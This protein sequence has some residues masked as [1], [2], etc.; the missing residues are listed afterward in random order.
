MNGMHSIPSRKSIELNFTWN[1]R[2]PSI[3][4]TPADDDTGN[5][6]NSALAVR[7]TAGLGT[8]GFSGKELLRHSGCRQVRVKGVVSVVYA[9][10]QLQ[11]TSLM[12][13]NNA[14]NRG[15]LKS[16]TR[17]CQRNTIPTR[18]RATKL[19]NKSL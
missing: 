1:Q 10:V 2:F 12:L 3:I 11:Q 13:C 18:T 6:K 5:A 14:V 9:F 15:R 16:R 17:L 7:D 8:L 19:L 4:G